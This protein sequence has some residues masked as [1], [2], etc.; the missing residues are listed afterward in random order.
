MEDSEAREHAKT[1]GTETQKWKKRNIFTK[2][3][4]FLFQE[5]ENYLWMKGIKNGKTRRG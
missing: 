3:P 2:F 4:R 1:G 5:L